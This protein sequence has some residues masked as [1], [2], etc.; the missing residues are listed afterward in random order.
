[1]RTSS[2]HHHGAK[3]ALFLGDALL[4]IL[5]DDKP[6]IP[7][8]N[9]WD[10]PGGGREG[11]ETPFETLAREVFEEV[12]LTVTPAEVLW[13]AQ[14]PAAFD[15]TVRVAFFVIQLPARRADDIIFGDEGQ[16]WALVSYDAFCKMK[17]VIP[18]YHARMQR[19]IDETGG[20]D[21]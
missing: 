8:P 19:W 17:D 5:R 7:W 10:F 3:A 6:D 21:D 14:F 16:R 20:L 12:G 18:S 2:E 1:L 4:M 13:Q 11:D 15:P 9:L